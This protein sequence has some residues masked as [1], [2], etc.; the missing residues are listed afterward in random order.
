M[1]ASCRCRSSNI[2]T[3]RR[4]RSTSARP[5]PARRPRR[6]SRRVTQVIEQQLTGID[7][8]I[9][10]QATSNSAG[11]L[12]LVVTFNKGTNPDIAQVQVQNKVQQALPRLPQQ[13]QAQGLTV[14]KSNADFLMVVALYD[15]S[16]KSTSV[17]VADYLVSN[18]QDQIGRLQGVG[19]YTVFGAQYAMR[20]WLDPFKL[21]SFSLTPGDIVT[22]LQ[23]QNTQIAAGQLGAQPSPPGQ[24]LSAIVTERSRLT[25]ADQ[26]R[27]VIVKT[28]SDGSLVRLR[29]VARV[30]LGAENYTN[31]GRLNGHPAVGMAIQLAP[32]QTR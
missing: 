22:A 29:D 4:R 8:L 20:I 11:A 28:Q 3:S 18:L 5:T 15:A 27:Q 12:T 6:S 21:A 24:M 30:E 32:G 1:A 26:F 23:A 10:F 9:Y 31:T 14:T 16:D 25:N 17:D 19:D 7:G 13:V 2:P